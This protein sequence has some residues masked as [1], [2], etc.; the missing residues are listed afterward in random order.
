MLTLSLPLPPSANH[1]FSNAPGKGR[2]KTAAYRDWLNQ[3]GWEL[4]AKARGHVTIT[5]PYRLRIKLSAPNMDCDNCVKSVS[6]ALQMMNIVS[7]DRLMADLHV[8]RVDGPR[9]IR[10]EVEAI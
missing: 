7:N 8:V 2:V 4:K 1:L 6:D 3:A 5:T 9:G 10:I